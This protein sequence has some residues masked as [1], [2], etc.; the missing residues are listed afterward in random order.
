MRTA[1]SRTWESTCG[2]ERKRHQEADTTERKTT[3]SPIQAQDPCYFL[4]GQPVQHTGH[5]IGVGYILHLLSRIVEKESY[6]VIGNSKEEKTEGGRLSEMGQCP[7]CVLE[8]CG[9]CL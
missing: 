8:R 1:V 6:I 5:V 2:R 7:L 9:Y 3:G 4:C